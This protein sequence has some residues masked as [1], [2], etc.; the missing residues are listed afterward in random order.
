MKE[1][2]PIMLRRWNRL[3][4]GMQEDYLMVN[5]NR[6]GPAPVPDRPTK[7]EA[8]NP[9]PFIPGVSTSAVTPSCF[10]VA[11]FHRTSAYIPAG[12]TITLVPLMSF[13]RLGNSNALLPPVYR[14]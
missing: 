8:S 2:P 11:G 14:P 12:E 5:N 3:R 4:Y 1:M 6:T 13:V 9:S 10:I 7:D